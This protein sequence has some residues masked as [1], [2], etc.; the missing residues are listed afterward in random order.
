MVNVTRDRL[1]WVSAYKYVA[2]KIKLG[3]HKLLSGKNRTECESKL[4][5]EPV[6]QAQELIQMAVGVGQFPVCFLG[7]C[8]PY[9][10]PPKTQTINQCR[11]WRLRSKTVSRECW[12]T[13]FSAAWTAAG[14]L[15]WGNSWLKGNQDKQGASS[16]STDPSTAGLCHS[17]TQS[18]SRVGASHALDMELHFSEF[19]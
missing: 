11:S 8:P 13:E 5:I 7:L 4:E 19:C 18:V 6:L 3:F 9:P 2:Q 14:R 10:S 1:T 17:K 12:W 15:G 16:T